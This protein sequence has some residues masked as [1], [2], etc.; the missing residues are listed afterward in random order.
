MDKAVS[1]SGA[2]KKT[3]GIKSKKECV[4]LI[5]MIK[6]EIGIGVVNLR[7]YG[8]KDNASNDIRFTCIPGIKPVKHPHIIPNNNPIKISIIIF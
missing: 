8:E 5:E 6:T 3:D 1:E 4:I 2:P 7:R